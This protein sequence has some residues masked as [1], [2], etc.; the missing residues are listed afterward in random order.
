MKQPG[1][2]P[3]DA[4]R[5]LA[6]E[7]TRFVHGEEGLQQAIRATEGLRPGSET[8]LDVATLEALAA[9]CP[10]AS[11]PRGDVVG[12]PVADV[13]VACG[14]QPS[15]TAARK[16]IKGGGVRLNNAKVEDEAAVVADS[17]AIGGRMLLLAAG[18]KNKMIVRIE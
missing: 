3:N 18:K 13:M 15:K 2:S 10:S 9:D 17:D 14:L 5:R 16:L 4:Q 12:K 1:Y 7:V 6:E 8:E 11:L